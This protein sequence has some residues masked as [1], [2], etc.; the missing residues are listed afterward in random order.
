MT[1]NQKHGVAKFARLAVTT[2]GDMDKALELFEK[3]YPRDKAVIP[4]LR[5]LVKATK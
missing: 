4:L 2:G 5:K 1:L 3:N